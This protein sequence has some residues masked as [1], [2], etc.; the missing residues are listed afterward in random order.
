MTEGAPTAPERDAVTDWG[1]HFVE[2]QVRRGTPRE[3]IAPLLVE[4]GMDEGPAH[5]LVESRYADI[6]QAV[7]A[8]QWTWRSLAPAAVG[9][10]IAALLGGIAWAWIVR[11]TEYEIG[12]AAWGIG[13]LAG[14]SV[15]FLARGRRGLP[16]QI[17]AVVAAI[18][19]VALGKYLTY[20][21]GVR[22][23]VEAEL[24]PAA[25][26]EVS[27]FDTELIGFFFEDL[28]LVFSGFDLLWFGFAIFSAW[29]VLR[30]REIR[31][32]GE[33]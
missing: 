32:W 11:T 29:G 3:Q 7:E 8:E 21:D 31:Q 14:F 23:A 24:G 12:F 33:D 4:R 19:G 6:H 17:I 16:L 15:L 18:L 1:E 25:A 9:G 13:L 30:V 5:S 28:S 22:M 2:E 26:D 27:A 10:V 20:V